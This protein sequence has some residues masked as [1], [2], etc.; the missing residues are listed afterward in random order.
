MHFE[1]IISTFVVKK[2]FY[3]IILIYLFYQMSIYN[4]KNSIIIYLIC[5][6]RNRAQLVDF[7]DLKICLFSIFPIY[8]EILL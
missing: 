2:I 5:V 4:F 7:R 8:I 3:S 1:F 6:T